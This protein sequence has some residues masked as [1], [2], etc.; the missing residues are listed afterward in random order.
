MRMRRAR[1]AAVLSLSIATVAVAPI[2]A[3]SSPI[4]SVELFGYFEPQLT[5]ASLDRQ[6]MQLSSNKLRI[7][8]EAAPSDRLTF[9]A[10]LNFLTYHGRTWYRLADYVPDKLLEGLSPSALDSYTLTFS[11]GYSL[12]NAFLKYAFSKFDLTVG[13]QQIS[14]GTGYAWNPT[15]MFNTKD[16]LDPTYENPGH[17]AV[18][19]EVPLGPRGT[20]TLLYSPDEDWEDSGKFV[21][22]KLPAGHFDV[23]LSAGERTV[24]LTDFEHYST[25]IERRTMVGGDFSGELLGLGCWGE[26]AQNDMSRSA[27]YFEGLLGADYT[28]ESGLYVLGELYVNERGKLDHEDY[29]LNDWLRFLTA[30]TRTVTRTQLYLY[31]SY[32]ATDLLSVGGSILTSLSDGSVALVPT[33]EYNM[34][35]NLDLTFF[36]NFYLGA[37]GTAF[38]SGLGQGFLLR[39]RYYF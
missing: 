17:N 5:I 35:T 16:V 14:P 13:K 32:P 27:D 2:T 18:T 33:L 12:D 26:F 15:D 38:S 21:R 11:D 19:A 9:G 34:D 10:N 25:L 4:D 37:E 7:D 24:R 8:L 36:G 23:S 1:A 22:V 20:A 28:F 6:T 3:W 31:S 39:L 29:T 30:Q